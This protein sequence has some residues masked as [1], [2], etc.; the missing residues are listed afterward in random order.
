MSDLL[1]NKT[2]CLSLL[3]FVS[4]WSFAQ[5]QHE[6]QHHSEGMAHRTDPAAKLTVSDDAAAR[7]LTVRIGPLN[8]PAHASHMEIA[9]AA[10]QM[11]TVPVEGWFTA[12]HPRLVDAAGN[13]LPSRMLHHVA[14]W[15]TGR[16]DSS[17]PTSWSTSSAPAAR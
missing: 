12:Y 16:P 1:M 8:L 17:A 11:L 7:V 9:Q 13:A 2:L 4:A 3:L 14:F 10:S 15:H 6:H 5:H